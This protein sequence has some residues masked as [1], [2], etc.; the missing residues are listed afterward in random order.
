MIRIQNIFY[1]LSYAFKTLREEGYYRCATE[2]FE[3][4][5]DLL[6]A[7]LVRG[8]SVQ[9]KRGLYRD[10]LGKSESLACPKGKIEISSSVRNQTFI[11]QKLTCSF[12][13]FSENAYLNRILKSTMLLLRQL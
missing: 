10:Y 12:D 8:V 13:E 9:I 5:A 1:M 3:N 7:I 6:S 4:T 2:N 11:K